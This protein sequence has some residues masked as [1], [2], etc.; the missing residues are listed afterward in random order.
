MNMQA[1]LKKLEEGILSG[2]FSATDVIVADTFVCVIQQLPHG[3]AYHQTPLANLPLQ[4]QATL[5]GKKVGEHVGDCRIVGIFD[6]WPTMPT[7]TQ[8]EKEIVYN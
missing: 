2:L 7:A 6:I 3:T 8:A 5:M 1:L 4:Y